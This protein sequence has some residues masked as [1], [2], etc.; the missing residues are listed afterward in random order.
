MRRTGHL[1][2]CGEELSKGQRERVQEPSEWKD[3]RKAGVRAAGTQS[4]LP[5]HSSRASHG[6][7]LT[8]LLEG[9]HRL[10]GHGRKLRSG[11]AEGMSGAE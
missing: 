11:H 5:T 8:S 6:R 4:A 10:P 7:T 1:R 2:S 9:T 3:A